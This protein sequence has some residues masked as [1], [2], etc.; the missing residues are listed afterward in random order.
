MA[1]KQN[2]NLI[3]ALD[4]SMTGFGWVVLNK[5]GKIYNQ[6]C[7]KTEPSHKKLGIRKGDDRVRRIMEINTELISIIKKYGIKLIVSEQPHGSQS[8][9][10]AVMIG[11]VAGIVQ[12]LADSFKIAVE[13]YF[14]GDCKH[15]L[16]GVRSAGKGA[17]IEAIGKKYDITFTG[18]KYKDEAVA[19]A[20]AVFDIAAAQSSIIRIL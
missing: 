12:T 16:L 7:I 8:A 6:G 13:Y 17:T 15:N 14:G 3:L 19:D 2:T 4:P 1:T 10:A 18:T 11:I 9:V 20:M 5:E